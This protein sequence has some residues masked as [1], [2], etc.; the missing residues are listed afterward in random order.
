MSK[1]SKERREARQQAQKRK[2]IMIAGV[3][4][5]VVFG[6]GIFTFMSSQNSS[7]TV[8]FPD[9]H[10][11]SFTGT[12]DQ[13]LVATHTGLVSYS[14]GS[15]SKPTLPINDYMGYSGTSEGFFSSGHPGA[16]SDLI[17]PIGLVKSDDFGETIQT[18]NFLGE[19]D[20]HVMGASY[21]GETVYVLN[22]APNSLLSA[23]LH[24][25]LDGGVTWEQSVAEG[26]NSGPINLAVHPS[27]S[28]II[29]IATERGLYFSQDFGN[30]FSLIDGENV[31]TMV[32]FDPNGERLIYGY[33]G[34]FEF[35]LDTGEIK[36]FDSLPDIESDQAI[37]YA[38]I[39]AE[40][41][42]IAFATTDRD[43]FISEDNGD[44][45]MQIGED[46]ISVTP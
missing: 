17:N 36:P 11:I 41:D 42:E 8:P 44:T 22:P 40:R 14:N 7:E 30:S 31:V 5:I 19:T 38:D 3:L 27:E 23:G 46:G 1:K 2:N 16:G 33:Q 18:I 28:N 45:W 39:N 32:R 6:F 12:G 4:L 10:G 26:L 13:L 20:F 24:Y 37:I 15:W 34:L 21:F 25:S 29:G 9:I 43:I 35:N